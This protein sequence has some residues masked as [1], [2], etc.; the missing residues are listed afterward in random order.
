MAKRY[1]QYPQLGRLVRAMSDEGRQLVAQWHR[2]L[3]TGLEGYISRAKENV[4]SAWEEAALPEAGLRPAGH[5]VEKCL[6][7]WLNVM[8]DVAG[9]IV[10]PSEADWCC[11][12]GMMVHPDPCP[13]HGY[14]PTKDYELG[15]VIQRVVDGVRERAVCVQAFG[16]DEGEVE[17]VSL[18][19]GNFLTPNDLW[20]SDGWTVI[21]RV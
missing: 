12:P 7:E 5:A 3:T 4:L 11:K 19:R 21:G 10:D 8:R 6:R 16:S 15:T 13:Q 18:E 17:W 2:V 9:I 20:P 1:D 14:D